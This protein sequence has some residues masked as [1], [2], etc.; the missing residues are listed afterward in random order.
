MGT[1]MIYAKSK[2]SVVFKYFVFAIYIGIA[3][4]E[5]I[6]TLTSSAIRLSISVFARDL[7]RS[8]FSWFENTV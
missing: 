4:I 7:Q 8:D 1:V 3:F 6:Q 2:L 5:T